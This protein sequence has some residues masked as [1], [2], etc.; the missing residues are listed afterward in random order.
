MKRSL[1]LAA[2]I[3]WKWLYWI[4]SLSLSTSYGLLRVMDSLIG[5][6]RV[7]K[8]KA[9]QVKK[10]DAQCKRRLKRLH[11]KYAIAE[12][13]YTTRLV[14]IGLRVLSSQSFPLYLRK[15]VLISIIAFF[16]PYHLAIYFL[17]L[18]LWNSCPFYSNE[19]IV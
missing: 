17:N 6:L 7:E 10:M 8:M 19:L 18:Q 16:V 12:K 1:I 9:M 3:L 15:A 11:I 2:K 4:Q 14:R 5:P 13:T